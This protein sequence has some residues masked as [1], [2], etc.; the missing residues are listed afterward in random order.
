MLKKISSINI[1]GGTVD[2]LSISNGDVFVDLSS[3][4]D[5]NSFFKFFSVSNIKIT[6]GIS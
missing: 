5:E 4:L 2:V 1:Y 6:N 3:G